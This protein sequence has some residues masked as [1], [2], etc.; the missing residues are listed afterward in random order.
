MAL[1]HE[2]LYQSASLTKI[3]LAEYI[4]SL[5]AN[6]FLSYGVTEKVIRP[7]INVENVDLDVDTMIPCALIINEL[8][9]NSLKHAFP[10]SWRTAAET[11]EIRIDLRHDGGNT[12]LLT[13]SDNGIG[14]PAGFDIQKCESLG[15]KLVNVLVRQLRGDIQLAVNGGTEFAIRFEA[16]TRK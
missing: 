3:D 7:K 1:I 15:L 13:V 8:V 16:L 9:S 4:Q 5:A 10:D 11:G 12:F 6:L 2:K 14:M